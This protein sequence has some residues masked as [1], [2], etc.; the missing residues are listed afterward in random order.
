MKPRRAALTSRPIVSSV[1]L[2]TSPKDDHHGAMSA[3]PALSCT[4]LRKSITHASDDDDSRE[5]RGHLVISHSENGALTS[6]PCN[7][8]WLQPFIASRRF[9]RAEKTSRRKSGRAA[10]ILEII[11]LVA[12]HTN[13]NDWSTLNRVYI[14]SWQLGRYL[15]ATRISREE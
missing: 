11:S 4:E 10:N 6:P 2:L 12:M 7:G 1:P 5:R 3:P 13:F 9:G 8:K 14:Y 15:N